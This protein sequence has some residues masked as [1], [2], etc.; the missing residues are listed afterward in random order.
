MFKDPSVD[1][2]IAVTALIILVIS[3]ALAGMIP[4]SRAV[5][6]RPIEALRTE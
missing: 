5:K 4:A 1:F 3:G 6:I 2:N